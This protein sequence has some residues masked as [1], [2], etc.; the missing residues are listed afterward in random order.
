MYKIGSEKTSMFKM[1]TVIVALIKSTHDLLPLA[2]SDCTL[3]YNLCADLWQTGKAK[4]F[5]N[6]N[7]PS[8]DVNGERWSCS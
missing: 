1:C 7:P 8:Q 2:D 5:I 6:A 3:D 4:Y